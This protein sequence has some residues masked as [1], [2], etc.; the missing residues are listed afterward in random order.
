MSL[1]IHV[2]QPVTQRR[3]AKSLEAAGRPQ[4][5]VAGGWVADLAALRQCIMLCPFCAPKFNPASHHYEVWR[6][7]TYA[8]AKCDG[9]KQISRSTRVYIHQSQHHDVGEWER[10][11]RGRWS[12]G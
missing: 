7:D 8:I 10:P 2:P 9:C 4:T 3:I 6:R 11:R 1:Q 5:R 12:K